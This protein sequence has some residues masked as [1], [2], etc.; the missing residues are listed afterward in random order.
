MNTQQGQKSGKGNKMENLYL[1]LK[2]IFV[3]Y[4]M[5]MDRRN[6]SK[7]SIAG[8]N[9]QAFFDRRIISIAIQ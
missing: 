2:I 3:P 1:R 9:N 6:N 4:D 5:W 8:I 7:K